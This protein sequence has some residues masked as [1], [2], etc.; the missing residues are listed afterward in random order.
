MRFNLNLTT[1]Y[2]EKSIRSSIL[3]EKDYRR[4][5][6]RNNPEVPGYVPTLSVGE[7]LGGMIC[8]EGDEVYPLVFHDY[9]AFLIISSTLDL[10]T[11][12]T[13]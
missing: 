7:I 4:I 5:P 12:P 13:I 2:S 6:V 9:K 8:C 10:E 1:D 3:G 11:A